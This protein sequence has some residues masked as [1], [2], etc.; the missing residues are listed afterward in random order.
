MK[1]QREIDIDAFIKANPTA[2][3]TQELP[4]ILHGQPDK[5]PIY[6]LPTQL[7][8]F[9]IANGRFAAEA[10]EAEKRLKRKLDATKPDDAKLI[11]KLLLEQD[12][13]SEIVNFYRQLR[14][15]GSRLLE[16]IRL[17]PYDRALY[18][19]Y[20]NKENGWSRQVIRALTKGNNGKAFER[21]EVIW[22]NAAY[23]KAK[24][25]NRVPIRLTPKEKKDGKINPIR[26][27]R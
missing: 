20:L 12:I 8:V 14:N 25:L 22:F 4:I 10:L 23:K 15:N 17:T 3:E 6:R 11:R 1:S 27:R 9:N 21:K 26:Q 13:N 2:L 16:L 19:K 7:L 24:R 18:R 5:R